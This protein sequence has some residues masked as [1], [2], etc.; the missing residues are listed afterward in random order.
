VGF[1]VVTG[2]ALYQVQLRDRKRNL[3]KLLIVQVIK[4]QA[5]L[6][7]KNLITQPMPDGPPL[8]VIV[9]V[10]HST[11]FDEAFKSGLFD[12]QE[13]L[14]LSQSVGAIDVYNL[15]VSMLQ[16]G[17]AAVFSQEEVGEDSNEAARKIVTAIMNARDDVLKS[18]NDLEDYWPPKEI[19][20]VIA[21]H[22]KTTA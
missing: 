1:A 22:R 20:E 8:E 17:A 11:V 5:Q 10:L 7:E 3:R 19:R 12:L 15:H 14:L 18:T 21:A 9:Q 2:F 13:S 16:S 4:I 6:D